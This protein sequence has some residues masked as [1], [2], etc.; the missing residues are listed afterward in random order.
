MSSQINQCYYIIFDFKYTQ[1]KAS[2]AALVRVVH[3]KKKKATNSTMK[4]TQEQEHS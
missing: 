2:S 1:I 4:K 3:D